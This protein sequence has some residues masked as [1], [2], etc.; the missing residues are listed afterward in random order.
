MLGL[1]LAIRINKRASGGS[2]TPPPTRDADTTAF[3]TAISIPDDSTL[4]Y[5]GT[6]QEITGEGM[7]DAVDALVVGLKAD[8]LWTG[9]KALYPMIGGTASRHERNLKNP[10]DTN[11]AHRILW[12]GGVTHTATGAKGNGT[13]GYGDCNI[14]P[15]D[16]AQDSLMG[17]FYLIRTP[18]FDS[19]Q[20]GAGNTG[21]TASRFLCGANHSTRGTLGWVNQ[22]GFTDTT[23]ITPQVGNFLIQRTPT[24]SGAELYLNGTFEHEI[25]EVLSSQV[26]NRNVNLFCE[27]NTSKLYYS[28]AELA[29]AY[30]SSS[31]SSSDVTKLHNRIT[32]YQT[33]LGRNV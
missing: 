7:W 23:F 8:S 33:G 3:M 2:P 4:Y 22:Y 30:L 18:N 27:N 29:I 32:T 25:V 1:G 20:M 12:G 17:G 16:F 5:S 6:P 15:S 13:N 14:Q 9:I 26:I 10:A 24:S 21:A 28:D 19:C 31:L 11:A